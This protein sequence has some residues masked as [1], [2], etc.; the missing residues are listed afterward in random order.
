M[1]SLS[2]RALTRRVERRVYIHQDCLKAYF[3]NYS[4]P[5]EINEEYNQDYG[6]G[7]L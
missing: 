7:F 2:L 5:Q 4:I 1:K 6:T 3:K